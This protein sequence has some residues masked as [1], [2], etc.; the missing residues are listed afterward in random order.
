MKHYC[1]CCGTREIGE[2]ALWCAPCGRHVAKDG[3]L[4]DRTYFAQFGQPC[5]AGK[6]H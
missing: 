3:A 2:A 5:P 4:W 6:G 1:G